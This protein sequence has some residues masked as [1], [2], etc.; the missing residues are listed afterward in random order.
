MDTNTRRVVLAGLLALWATGSAWAQSTAPAAGGTGTY[1]DR[2][3]RFIVP[4][5][6]GG[7]TDVIGRTAAAGMAAVLGQQIVVE[8]IAGASGNIGALQGARAQP[9]GYTL[10]MVTSATNAANAYL[11]AKL[12]FHPLDDFT[13]ITLFADNPA[14][15]VVSNQSPYKSVKDL[16]DAARAAPGKL[17]FG[18]GGVGNTGH[19]AG[20]LFKS[21]AKIDTVH[22]PYRGAAPATVDVMSGQIAYLFDSGGAANVVGGKVRGLGVA[23]EKRLAAL[24]DMPTFKEQGM[25]AMVYSTWF[26]LAAPKGLPAPIAEKLAA[27]WATAMQKPELTKRLVDI[28][29]EPLANTPAAFRAYWKDEL[30]RYRDI[31]KL[32]GAKPE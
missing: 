10:V 23:G 17:S 1:P 3:I 13:P 6:A 5:P 25:P 16:V 22:V 30:E 19:L 32:S 26:G 31:V 12:P 20:E 21:L 7:P 27:A 24:P 2:P 9:D 11:F 8:N 15:L 28:G 4:W 29:I 18:S 14:V